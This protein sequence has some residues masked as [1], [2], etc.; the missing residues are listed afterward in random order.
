MRFQAGTLDAVGL[1]HGPAGQTYRL[2]AAGYD[3]LGWAQLATLRLI[4]AG[5]QRGSGWSSSFWPAG[6]SPTSPGFFLLDVG[7]TYWVTYPWG[8]SP[9][10]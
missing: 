1:T 7:V 4:I 2:F 6:T 5:W 3:V 10:G 8:L 9:G